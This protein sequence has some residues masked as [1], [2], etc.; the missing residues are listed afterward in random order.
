MTKRTALAGSLRARRDLVSPA[1]VGLPGKDRRKVAGLRREEVAVLAG[2]GTEYYIRL[3]QGREHNSSHEVLAGIGRALKLN[4]DAVTYMAGLARE[5]PSEQTHSTAVDPAIE[6]LM[7]GWPLAAA[8]VPTAASR[9][10]RPTAWRARCHRDTT[11]GAIGCAPCSSTRTCGTSIGTG[12]R[13][14]R[15]PFARSGPSSVETPTRSFWP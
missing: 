8:Q 1:D 13:R 6:A 9:W 10:S 3:E 7:A 14:R 15:G 2:I 4:G 5:W 12:T 11:S